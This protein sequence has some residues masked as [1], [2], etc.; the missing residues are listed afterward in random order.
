MGMN[1]KEKIKQEKN[2]KEQIY[3]N[4]LE[5]AKMTLDLE[6]K[7]ENSLIKQSGQMITAFSIVTAV[8]IS[9][10]RLIIELYSNYLNMLVKVTF[11]ISLFLFFV[12]LVIAILVQWRYKYQSLPSPQGIMNHIIDN[13]ESYSKQYSR[14][15]NLVMTIDSIWKRKKEIN[16]IRAKL[17]VY[18]MIS[19]F[20]ALGIT[21]LTFI[22]TL[23]NTL[24]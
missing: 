11:V 10:Y 4:I 20:S 24:L 14:D 12:S 1:K 19:F 16:D 8:Y 9:I 18:S 2:N 23:I 6:T 7:R 21:F 15:A 22:I 5:Y 17:I 3:S 13:S